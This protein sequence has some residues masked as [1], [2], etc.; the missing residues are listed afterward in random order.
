MWKLIFDASTSRGMRCNDPNGPRGGEFERE[1]NSLFCGWANIYP[2]RY[3]WD[4]IAQTLVLWPGWEAEEAEKDALAEAQRK[5]KAIR[6]KYAAMLLG[7]A[8]PYGPEE[9][10]TWKTQE[11]E[12]LQFIADNSAPCVMIRAMAASRGITI[13]LMVEKIMENAVLFRAASGQI[14]GLQQKD[15]DQLQR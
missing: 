11:E 8:K 4:D 15:L 12:A 2:T 7:I 3:M 14:L 13:E 1:L 6:D 5:E 9:R 10:E